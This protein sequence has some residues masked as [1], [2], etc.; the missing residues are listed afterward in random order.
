M[1]RSTGFSPLLH[2]ARVRW[3]NVLS[4][5]LADPNQ[6]WERHVRPIVTRASR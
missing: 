4:C 1:I 3:G 6:R 5:D 2:H